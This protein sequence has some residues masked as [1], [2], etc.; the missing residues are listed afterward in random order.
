MNR[1][2]P[3][4]LVLAVGLATLQAGRFLLIALVALAITIVT[5]PRRHLP[6]APRQPQPSPAV[7]PLAALAHDLRH[8]P[9]AQL[10]EVAGTRR[11][12]AKDRLISDLL[13]LP[14]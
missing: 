1:P 11:K 3:V 10:R 2:H 7:A 6:P 8:L 12:L 4:E 14:I 13:A 9:S 5:D